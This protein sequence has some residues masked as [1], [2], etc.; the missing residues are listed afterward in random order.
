MYLLN[1]Q[2]LK[3]YRLVF[4]KLDITLNEFDLHI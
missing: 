2:Q 4:K 1:K 3:N